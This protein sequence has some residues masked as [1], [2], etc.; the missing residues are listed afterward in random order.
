MGW[1]WKFNLGVGFLLWLA[2]LAVL[3]QVPALTS[4][5]PAA[6]RPVAPALPLDADQVR[7]DLMRAAADRARLVAYT[8]VRSNQHAPRQ[9]R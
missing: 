9:C 7:A 6:V 1:S 2:A 5:S 8:P 3:A 4:P